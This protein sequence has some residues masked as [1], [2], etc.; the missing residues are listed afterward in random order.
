MAAA[1]GSHGAASFG[2][3]QLPKPSAV[4]IAY[5]AHSD[6]GPSEPPTFVAVGEND[7]I[8]PPSS[9]ER[10]VAVLRSAGTEVVYRKYKNVGHGFG[11]GTGT[12]AKGWVD[13]AVRFWQRFVPTPTP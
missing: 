10:R 12:S 13:D 7:T 4:V 11:P 3:E 2:G 1:I 9:M 8:A 5:T 6:Y